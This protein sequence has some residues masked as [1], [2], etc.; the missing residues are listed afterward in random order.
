[1]I[2]AWML[3]CVGIGLAFVVAGR[4]IEWALHLAGCQTRWAWCGALAGTL[5]LPAAALLVPEAF[6]TVPVPRGAALEPVSVLPPVGTQE[7]GVP[8]EQRFWLSDLDAALRWGW[9]LSS[10]ALIP[11]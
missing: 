10:A 1:M 5:L 3:Y 4:G 6:S 2:A 7:T 11:N 9:G 8:S